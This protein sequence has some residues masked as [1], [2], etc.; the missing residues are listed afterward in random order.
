MNKLPPIPSPPGKLWREFRIQLLPVLVFLGA[1]VAAGVLWKTSLAAPSLVGQVESI[2]AEVRSPDTGVLAML[3]VTDHQVVKMGDVI[4][5]VD[6]SD[7][8]TSSARANL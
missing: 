2:Q 6:T 3:Y 5:E 8:R 4:G 1:V 7:P